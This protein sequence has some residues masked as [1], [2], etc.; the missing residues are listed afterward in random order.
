MLLLKE[1][2]A[3]VR[4]VRRGENRIGSAAL[5][6]E[7]GGPTVATVIPVL[8]EM[9]HIDRCLHGLLNQTLAPS[10]HMILV[11]DGGSTDGTF[12]HV[13]R[14]IKGHQDDRWPSIVLEMN[15]NRTVA[16]ARN[17]ALDLLPPSVELVVEMI[18]HATV[19]AEH[20]E[21]RLQAWT[22]CQSLSAGPLAGVGVRVEPDE[23][24][25]HRVG[26]WV[27][28]ALASPLGRSGG[29]FSRFNRPQSTNVPAFVMHDRKAVTSIGGWDESFL[30]SQ[31]SDVSMRLVK[32][33]FD[34]YRHPLPKVSMHKRTSLMQWWKMGHRYGFWR[35]KVLQKHPTRAKWQ[36]FLPLAGLVLLSILFMLNSPLT[37]LLMMTYGL[38]LVAAGVREAFVQRR[39]SSCLGVPLCLAMLHTS[40]SIG[41]VDG[42]VR[43]GR[44]PTDRSPNK[45]PI[46]R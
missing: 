33:G 26:D 29:Q 35:T 7:A 22:E 3:K 44:F 5:M 28:G 8:N 14:V 2:A 9:D 18:G 17:L 27:E 25:H 40:F 36:E 45:K 10:K 23:N 16:H 6:T 21:H 39:L 4:D 30:T 43:K 41:L 1:H 38:A 46:D 34:L 42:L 11:L 12:E 19:E 13:E 15:P 37:S 24:L 32:A 20:L 31:D